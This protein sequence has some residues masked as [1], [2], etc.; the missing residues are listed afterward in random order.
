MP[1]IIYTIG[2]STRTLDEFVEILNAH[3]IALLVDIR[4]IPKSRHNPQF[5]KDNLTRDLPRKG[6][7]YLHLPDL[8]GLRKAQKNSV[9]AGWRNAS[10]RGFAD[11]MQTRAFVSALRRLMQLGK[12]R[13]VAVMC[14]EGNPFRCHRSLVADALTVRKVHVLHISSKTSARAHTMTKFARIDGTRITYPPP[15]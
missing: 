11:Y 10:F 9:N 4:T 12:S 6:I 15:G 1:T 5:N 14:A 13:R 7:A 3:A 2:H 8:G